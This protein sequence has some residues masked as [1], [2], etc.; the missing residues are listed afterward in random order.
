MGEDKTYENWKWGCKEIEVTN[1]TKYLGI[2]IDCRV[3]WEKEVSSNQRENT[4]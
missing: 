4:K 1:G 2:I 3:K